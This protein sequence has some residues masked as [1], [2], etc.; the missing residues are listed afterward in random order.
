M[1][2]QSHKQQVVS[3]SS[4]EVEYRAMTQ[5]SLLTELGFFV[6]VPKPI[7]CDNQAAIFNLKFYEQ[8]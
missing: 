1:T 8:I 5:A 7:F 4:I 3:L 2:W 6:R